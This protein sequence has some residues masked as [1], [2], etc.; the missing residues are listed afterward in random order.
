MFPPDE[1]SLT[2]PVFVKL[3]VRKKVFPFKTI[4]PEEEVKSP[5]IDDALRVNAVEA[6]AKFKFIGALPNCVNAPK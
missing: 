5:P 3:F 1:T 2:V 6:P 4:L